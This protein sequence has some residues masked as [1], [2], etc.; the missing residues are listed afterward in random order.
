MTEPVRVVINDEF[1]KELESLINRYGLESPSN[2][3]DFILA[4]YLCGCLVM[5]NIAVDRREKW[6]G[7]EPSAIYT[8]GPSAIEDTQ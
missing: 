1:R 5:F 6:Y 4:D 7:R 3:P 2:T 8:R